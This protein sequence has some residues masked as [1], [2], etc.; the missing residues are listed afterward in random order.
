MDYVQLG[1]ACLIGLVFAVSAGTKL[2]DLRGFVDSVPELVPMR[3][4]LVRPVAAA[5]LGLEVLVPVTVA[6][7]ALR[8]YGFAVALALLVAF[9]WAIS[10][11]LR[12]GRRAPCRCFGASQ[13]PLGPRQLVRNGV[14]SAVAALGLVTSVA[15]T[16]G[17]GLP[18]IAG[19]AVAAVAGLV[20]AVLIVSFDDLVDL[21]ARNA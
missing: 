7:P 18:P 12:R 19:S 8:V 10:T 16:S 5:V 14:L 15:A 9:T 4:A 2:R 21:F 17:D 13:A 1:C 3:S 20:G 11:A 6:V